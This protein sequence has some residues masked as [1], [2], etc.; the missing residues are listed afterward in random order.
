MF[1]GNVSGYGGSYPGFFRTCDVNG[2]VKQMMKTALSGNLF[3]HGCSLIPQA[4]Y[5]DGP[6]GIQLPVNNRE[7]PRSM[8]DFFVAH[9][10]PRFNITSGDILHVEGCPEIWAGDLEEETKLLVRQVYA[11]DFDLLCQHFGYC[12]TGENTCL[13]QVESMC[14]KRVLAQSY[15]GHRLPDLQ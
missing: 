9:G 15:R 14:P 2:A 6:Y 3:A 11:R 7:F 4:E 1:R 10:Y 13:Y 12:Q 8:N 5:F